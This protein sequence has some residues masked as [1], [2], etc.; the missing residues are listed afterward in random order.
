[1]PDGSVVVGPVPAGGRPEEA[2]QLGMASF[3][4]ASHDAVASV[5]SPPGPHVVTA[6]LI[7]GLRHPQAAP[8][9]AVVSPGA[10]A[11]QRPCD[12]PRVLSLLNLDAYLDGCGTA[13]P[14]R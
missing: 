10:V 8:F 13:D 12:P 7:L 14:V 11:P 1:M 4:V 2:H 6:H 3:G 5:V 9:V